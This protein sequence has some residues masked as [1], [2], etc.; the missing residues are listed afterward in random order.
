MTNWE[1]IAL[2]E[3]PRVFLEFNAPLVKTALHLEED[4]PS[5]GTAYFDFSNNE[6]HVSKKFLD[7]LETLGKISPEEAIRGIYKHEWGHYLIYPKECSTLMVLGHHGESFFGKEHC[8]E[9]LAYWIDGGNNVPQM[10]RQKSG[11]DVRQLF[12]GINRILEEELTLTPKIKQKLQAVGIDGE[13]LRQILHT[14]SPD[15]LMLAYYQWASEEDFGVDIRGEYLEEKLEKNVLLPQQP[16]GQE[17]RQIKEGLVTIDFLDQ[18]NELPSYLMFGNIL[19][20]VL[21]KRDELLQPFRQKMFQAGLENLLKLLDS[22][23]PS[24]PGLQDFTDRQIEEGLDQIIRKYGKSRYE[25]ILKY[26]EDRTGRKFSGTPR[27][28]S[29][30]IG[31]G[32]SQLQF[33]DDQ[34]PYFEKKARTYG[35]YIYRKPIVTDVKENYPEGQKEFEIGDPYHLL[36]LFSSGGLILPGVTKRHVLAPGNRLDRQFKVPN[37]TLWLDTS[38]SMPN[39]RDGSDAVLASFILARN[40]WEN[41]ASVGVVNW[42]TDMAAILPTRELDKVYSLLCA[43]WGGGTHLNIKK[44]R[45]YFE[46]VARHT[47]QNSFIFTN[48]QEYE[49]LAESLPD[50]ERRKLLEK[51]INI[52]LTKEVKEVYD[53][54]DTVIIT[55]G[56]IANLEE[57]IDYVNHT[58]ALT[59]NVIFLMNNR[60]QAEEWQKMTLMNT[61]IIPVDSAQDLL[62]LSLGQVKKIAPTGKIRKGYL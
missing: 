46:R 7:Q 59:R 15:R 51:N 37:L 39:S 25:K 24:A 36:N 45:D 11:A 48:E 20:E 60:G 4:L 41:Q 50:Q 31:L 38:G 52:P 19:L 3:L 54:M 16:P 35:L 43:Y 2:Q 61:Q 33:N 6:T 14:Y 13:E 21:K 18:K 58:A 27:Q 22:K 23:F 5:A 57:V 12:R 32:S 9:I 49:H 8:E 28:P 40:Y 26:V 47:D 42:S 30:G 62:G 10:L 56:G 17:D 55:D 44:V 53:K 34:I 1:E 29:Q